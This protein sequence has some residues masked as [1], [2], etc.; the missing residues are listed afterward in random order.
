MNSTSIKA[1][2]QLGTETVSVCW[3]KYNTKLSLEGYQ[4]IWE[5]LMKSGGKS[6]FSNQGRTMASIAL[7]MTSGQDPPIYNSVIK[8]KDI[9]YSSL[10]GKPPGAGAPVAGASSRAAGAQGTPGAP[11]PLWS[12]FVLALA[13]VPADQDPQEL[14]TLRA[15]I[16]QWSS[17]PTYA[18]V[19]DSIN[20]FLAAMEA[21]GPTMTALHKAIA[22]HR[23]DTMFLAAVLS[24]CYRGTMSERAITK[25]CNGFDA[26]F[27]MREVLTLENV[28]VCY[29]IL[30]ALFP[31]DRDVGVFFKTLE[32]VYDRGTHLRMNLT[33]A[34]TR[35]A[36]AAALMITLAAI[37]QSK[38]CSAWGYL[39]REAPGEW[40]A[41]KAAHAILK[42][43]PYAGFDLGRDPP[44]QL[45]ATLYPSFTYCGL[46]ILRALDPNDTSIHYKGIQNSAHKA[47]INIKIADWLKAKAEELRQEQ[48]ANVDWELHLGEGGVN[49]GV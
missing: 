16:A 49:L 39:V 14:S 8:D 46:S 10:M 21:V 12:K 4:I 44:Q 41:F 19:S 9:V 26:S 48:I 3:L 25:M 38:N 29:Q 24:I 32:A 42:D 7:D 35:Y 5:F 27:E 47:G 40:E 43:N 37:R 15:A 22:N 31:H 18:D 34:Q 11:N 20:V 1:R 45:R 13:T 2:R 17:P 28:R 6:V 33:I 23:A 36:G 30:R